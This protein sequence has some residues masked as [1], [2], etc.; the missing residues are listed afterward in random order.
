MVLPGALLWAPHPRTHLHNTRT[1]S[2]GSWMVPYSSPSGRVA[3]QRT[4]PSLI[5][6]RSQTQ[7]KVS[8]AQFS[9]MVGPVAPKGLPAAA[10]AVSAP[11]LLQA[12]GSSRS[13][14]K[15][16]TFAIPPGSSTA[17]GGSLKP[18]RRRPLSSRSR[19]SQPYSRSRESIRGKL[20][21]GPSFK[22]MILLLRCQL[23][24]WSP[25]HHFSVFPR[26]FD[27]CFC[28]WVEWFMRHLRRRPALA[29]E[30]QL[31]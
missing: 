23:E 1:S 5:G 2:G 13:R 6:P 20:K 10:A 18:F 26:C 25:A 28:F 19:Y 30:S 31:V 8:G 9:Y 17:S 29:A 3:N 11:A 14:G 7:I 27:P 16:R 21:K 15:F 4:V 12:P 22:E 24:I